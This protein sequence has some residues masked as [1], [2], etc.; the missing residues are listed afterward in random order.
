MKLDI[1]FL[2]KLYNEAMVAGSGDFIAPMA[3]ASLPADKQPE[4]CVACHSCEQVCPQT[5]KIPDHLASFARKLG[6]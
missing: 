5:I 4:C 1:P 6:R 3:L 2:L